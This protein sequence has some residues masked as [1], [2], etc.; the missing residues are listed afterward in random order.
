[1][2]VIA[3]EYY[4]EQNHLEGRWCFEVLTCR[5]LKKA[6]QVYKDLKKSTSNRNIKLCIEIGVDHV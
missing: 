1:M 4:S 2:F 6:L 3:Y 5:T